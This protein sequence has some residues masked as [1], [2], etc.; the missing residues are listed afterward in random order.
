MTING[1]NLLKRIFLSGENN[2]FRGLKSL[3]YRL[4]YIM[5]P[6][7]WIVILSSSIAAQLSLLETERYQLLTLM[8]LLQ[9]VF[10][11]GAFVVF[12]KDIQDRSFTLFVLMVF[13][14]FTA[15]GLNNRHIYIWIFLFVL[16]ASLLFRVRRT[17]LVFAL[18]FLN[19]VFVEKVSIGAVL[20][21]GIHPGILDT[22]PFYAI[23]SSFL[24]GTIISVVVY[25]LERSFSRMTSLERSL[26]NKKTILHREQETARQYRDALQGNEL[27]FK[28]IVEY[29]FDGITILDREGNNKFVSNSTEKITGFNS[30][31]FKE[32]AINFDRVHP[33]DRQRVIENF[34]NITEKRIDNCTIYYR[35]LHKDGEWRNLEVTVTNLLDNPGIEGILFIYRDVTK[36][37]QAEQ[38]ARYFEFYDQLTGL[39]NQLM[40]AEK[41]L[42]EIERSAARKRS[43][44]VMCLGVN[45]FKDINGQY[46]TTFG[47]MV[48]KHIGSRL[49][50]NFRGDDFVSRMMGDKFLILFS[51]MKSENDVIAI[52]Q[53]TMSSFET[54]FW[55]DNKDVSVS[56]SIGISIYP[57]DGRR[58]DELI[59]N[60]ESAL[61]ICKDNRERT[62]A[63]FNKNQNE[64]LIR[65]I[66]IEKDIFNAIDNKAFTVYFQPKVNVQGHLAGAEAL[67]RW[68][69]GERGMVSP[70]QFIPI[71]ERNRSIIDIGKIVMEKTFEMVKTWNSQGLEIVEISI[72]VAP[73]QF[74]DPEF[75]NSVE[76]LQSQYDIDPGLI[77]FE[78]TETGIMENEKNSLQTMKELICK[79]Y[80]ISIDDFG[81]GYSSLNKLKDYPVSTLK[82]DKTFIDPVPNDSS[83]C[84]IVRTI[85]D[86]AHSLGYKVVAEGVENKAQF[87]L[88]SS[89]GCDM[90]QGYYFHK[91][92][93]SNQ[94]EKL[95]K[96]PVS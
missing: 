39:P 88:L 5:E 63:L 79:G 28:T 96:K 77:E 42:E 89:Y 3:R 60:S 66:Q 25:Y 81:T 23:I 4:I 44:A 17:I 70:G 64:D 50:S 11:T 71:S 26:E 67:I 51:D 68:F 85:I 69:D 36:H 91:P 94:F 80:S 75:I 20:E 76:N 74:S 73:M 49:K 24:A 33:D 87:Q 52:V 10:I 59:K 7:F 95:L 34:R 31:E 30:D 90:I 16:I 13:I 46:G 29:A 93:P 41:I 9:F 19:F 57:N 38:R 8:F 78:I 82:I 14:F 27:K 1:K 15:M 18:I 45:S 2:K 35:Y 6:L 84:N 58:K 43:F 54:P 72:N 92:M 47:D 55:I 32:G 53:K 65:R 48:L 56:A 61:F 37:M 12:R 22:I 83:A 21:E 62:Y 40:F 86:L